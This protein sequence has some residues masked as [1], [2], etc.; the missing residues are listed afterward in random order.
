MMQSDGGGEFIS[1]EFK[2]WLAESGIIHQVTLPY[3]LQLNGVAER[4]N[5]TFVDLVR[6]M[7]R[8]YRWNSGYLLLNR[9]LY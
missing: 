1:N 7:T 4:A 2:D 9:R 3:T 8:R 6:S 5:R